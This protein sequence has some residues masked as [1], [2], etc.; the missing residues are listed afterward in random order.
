ME[1]SKLKACNDTKHEDFLMNQA[2]GNA[3][4]ITYY[5]GSESKCQQT[6]KIVP[7]LQEIHIKYTLKQMKPTFRF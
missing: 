5:D 7:Y 6:K 4:L 3:H 2:V 1:I